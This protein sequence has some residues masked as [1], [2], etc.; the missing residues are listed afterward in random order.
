[1]AKRKKM[2]QMQ[3]FALRDGLV[4][5]SPY[6]IGFF[7][8][9]LYPIIASLYYSFTKYTVLAPPK[10]VGLLNYKRMFFSPEDALYRYSMYNTL[11]YS[12]F[13]IPL[14][15]VVGISIALLLNMKVRGMAIYRT[16]YY[17]PSIVPIVASSVL[18]RWI[19]NPQWGILNAALEKIGIPGPPWIASPEWSKPAIILMSCWAVGGAMVI[20]LAGL[21]DIPK[22]L[23]EAADIDGA[24]SFQK[25]IN[26]T[27]PMLTPTIFFNLI[28][29]LIGA[30]Q[31]FAP[32]Y[33]LT[34]GGPADSTTLYAFH[35]Y[36]TA[37]AYFRMGYAS[38]MAWILFLLIAFF[39]LILFKTSARWV[40]YGGQR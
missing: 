21:Q 19:L 34:Q 9:T 8:F 14:G 23:Y 4:F 27:I 7:G 3:K 40:Y 2:S 39:T 16:I 15:L 36:K 30:F 18:W 33:I 17:L 24:N 22:E 20:Y 35:L 25:I 1:M 10:W 28:M 5:A 38:A 12:A 31:F 11:Y 32:V 37:F 13:A 6:I 29:G 26:I